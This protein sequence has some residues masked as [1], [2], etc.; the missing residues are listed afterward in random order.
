MQQ[1]TTKYKARPKEKCPHC[2][3]DTDRGNLR[4]HQA[5]CSLLPSGPEMA[6]MLEK[7]VDMTAY[8]IA[9]KYGVSVTFTYSKITQTTNWTR[10]DLITR[11][12]DARKVEKNRLAMNT[13][14]RR[15]MVRQGLSF[16][17]FC[18]VANNLVVCTDCERTLE[19]LAIADEVPLEWKRVLNNTARQGTLPARYVKAFRRVINKGR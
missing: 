4:K 9:E 1:T 13:E 2:G 15:E 11:G 5:L 3:R 16:C 19:R 14:R 7:D 8:A 12:K 10:E 6:E 18:E 17:L